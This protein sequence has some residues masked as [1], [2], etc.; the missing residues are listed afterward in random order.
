MNNTTTWV[1]DPAH[2]EVFFKVKH[3]VITTVTGSFEKFEGKMI[4]P[5]DNFNNSVVEFSAD[6]ASINTNAP[7]RDKHLKSADFFDSEKHPKVE[8]RS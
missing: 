3:L 5:S 1:I 2:S 7:D 8:F 6:V 4:S